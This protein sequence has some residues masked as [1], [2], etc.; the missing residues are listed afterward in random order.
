MSYTWKHKHCSRR[1]LQ[2]QYCTSVI[3]TPAGI[4]ADN[5]SGGA[6]P[7]GAHHARLG[8][9]SLGSLIQSYFDNGIA[10]ST[11][12]VYSTGW[13]KYVQFC[14]TVG[15][16]PLPITEYSQ[17]LFI[18]HLS[19]SV[20]WKTIRSYLSA[21]RFFQIRAGLPDPNS[22]PTPQIPY[23]LKGIHKLNPDLHNQSANPSLLSFSDVFT[24]S[25]HMALSRLTE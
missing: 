7:A 22:T 13:K 9:T 18:A 3:L 5:S 6:R 20:Q 16:P 17:T 11:K 4:T 2:R 1:H 25:G 14:T 23:I 8:L 15:V 21:I 12:A 10:R 19:L 24:H